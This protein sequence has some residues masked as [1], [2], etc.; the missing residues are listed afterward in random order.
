MSPD[1]LQADTTPASRQQPGRDTAE[2][3]EQ[4]TQFQGPPQEFL[5]NLLVLQCRLA[6]ASRGALLRPAEQGQ[7]Q[8]LASVPPL[9]R[10][11]A[12]PVWLAQAVESAPAVFNSGSSAVKAL[13][14]QDA[15]YGQA[16]TRH[17][18]LVPIKQQGKVLSL[19]AFVLENLAPRDVQAQTQK[20]ELT[21]S[22]LSLYDMRLQLQKRQADL[23]RLQNGMGVL[24][25]VNTQEKFAAS[26]MALVNE[27]ASRFGADRVSLGLL[28][29]RS[30]HLKAMSHTEKLSR[31]MQLVQDLESAMEEC[32]DQDLEIL[33][34]H[35]EA[36]YVARAAADVSRKHG[37]TRILSLPLRHNGEPVG[38]LSLEWPPE[39]E[40]AEAELE[41]LRL[42]CDLVTARLM[43][44][45]EY[46][47][48]FG[49]KLARGLGRTGGWVVG[50]KHTWVKLLAIA[51][52]GLA[53]FLVFAKGEYNAEASF[54]LQAENPRIVAAPFEGFLEEV[55]VRP[56]DRVV[57]DETVLAKL[58]VTDMRL[59]LLEAQKEL[60]DYRTQVRAARRDGKQ[61]EV[62]IA[63]AKA[64]QIAARIDLLNYRLSQADLIA[65]ISGYVTQGELHR[66][67]GSPLK[68]G[69]LLFEI[70]PI[71]DLRAELKVPEDMI[72]DVQ[73]GSTGQLAAV[74]RPDRKLPFVVED[75][76]PMAEVVEGKNVFKVRVKLQQRPTWLKPGMEGL[77]KIHLGEK[78]YGWLWTRDLV[79]WVRMKL[80]I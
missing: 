13:P 6:S 42:T 65:P 20:L 15:M 3:I 80:W 60:L 47:R 7:V 17:L 34:P 4:L 72:I 1:R 49:A 22:L 71:D 25:A 37:P 79:N 73:V 63:E 10:D 75:I 23:G 50:A 64:E 70:A 40:V 51:I 61:G 76:Y 8:V 11:Q 59:R 33:Y 55:N 62:Q 39:R 9:N 66:K 43:N 12:T 46:D 35:E 38:V 57:A 45:F 67:V 24:A 30:V 56:G 27:L 26:A 44:V 58:D 28:K 69:D 14:K 52:L 21:T 31:K 78:P 41:A 16:D 18:V 19:A 29:G 5:G 36:T 53:A 77:A 2:L 68:T 74:G 48:W 54:V 32:I